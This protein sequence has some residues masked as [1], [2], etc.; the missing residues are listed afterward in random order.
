MP[1]H[2]WKVNPVELVQQ[3]EA[4]HKNP[5]A[6]ALFLWAVWAVDSLH[7]LDD[8]DQVFNTSLVPLAGHAPDVIDVAHARW[9][10]GT[11]ITS[12]DL[13]AA[14]LGRTFCANS[15]PREYD[16]GDFNPTRRAQ[17]P[18][19][20]Q[21][22]ID[23][24]LSDPQYGQAKA[25]RDWLTHSRLTR[26][27]AVSIGGPPQRLTLA[28]GSTRLAVRELIELARDLATRHVS[29]LLQLLPGL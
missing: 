22:W 1:P 27:F 6:G 19:D 26:H 5:A 28:I 9:A 10:T 25:A 12:L 14:G 13:C 24:V 3:F 23:R 29:D 15:G 2:N 7:Y 20:T 16:L 18:P 11:S 17:L 21:Q 4:R 8:L